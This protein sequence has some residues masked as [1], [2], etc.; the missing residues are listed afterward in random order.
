MVVSGRNLFSN[1]LFGL[2][3]GRPDLNEKDLNEKRFLNAKKD[4]WMV[5]IPEIFFS[6]GAGWPAARP[7]GARSRPPFLSQTLIK[8]CKNKGFWSKM[9]PQKDRTMTRSEPGSGSQV[10]SK[11]RIWFKKRFLIQKDFWLQ[12]SFFDWKS[13]FL[14]IPILIGERRIWLGIFVKNL[15][16]ER[17]PG[18]IDEYENVISERQVV[19]AGEGAPKQGARLLTSGDCDK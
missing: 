13:F 14:Q 10:D 4:F 12:K 18:L 1:Q 8:P 2:L 3:L 16:F 5:L 7:A 17:R 19:A 6:A 11:K 15:F 9:G